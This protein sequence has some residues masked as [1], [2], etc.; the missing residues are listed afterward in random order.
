[1]TVSAMKKIMEINPSQAVNVTTHKCYTSTT[2]LRLLQQVKDEKQYTYNVWGQKEQYEKMGV[3]KFEG[4]AITYKLP[5][6]KTH[7]VYNIGQTN[8]VETI[9]EYGQ[10][11]AN[12]KAEREAKKQ[13]PKGGKIAQKYESTIN[14][15]QN[16]I[17]TLKS[18]NETLKQSNDMFI[19]MMNA[20]KEKGVA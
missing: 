14:E 5:S 7:F 9:A 11:K 12:K 3:T 16:E 2:T 10:M 19:F 8:A 20:L 13:V 4:E 18:A 6:G 1:M 15:L 17:N